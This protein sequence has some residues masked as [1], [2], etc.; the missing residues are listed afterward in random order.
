ML[1]RAS[2]PVKSIFAYLLAGLVLLQTFSRELLVA[3]FMLNRA[4]ITARYCVNKSRPMLHCDGKCYFAKQLKKQEERQSKSAGPLKERLDMLPT[5]FG[6]WRF[7]PATY[8]VAA[9]GYGRATGPAVPTLSQR[10][11]FHP[12]QRLG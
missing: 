4:E 6:N 11:V 5:A 2:L 7:G 3:D 10:G 8:V 9:A 12:P 1:F